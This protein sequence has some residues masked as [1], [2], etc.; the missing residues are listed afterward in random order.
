MICNV[1]RYGI[2]AVKMQFTF[3]EKF[4]T[5][6]LPGCIDVSVSTKTLSEEHKL[7]EKDIT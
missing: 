4:M 1:D 7:K 3:L 6:V 2:N 5:D